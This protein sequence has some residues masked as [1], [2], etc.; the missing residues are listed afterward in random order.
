M[1]LFKTIVIIFISFMMFGCANT[2]PKFTSLDRIVHNDKATVYFYRIRGFV[3]G[4]GSGG[5]VP[6]IVNNKLIGKLENN[7]Y[8]KV[9]FTEGQYKIHSQNSNIIDRILNIN[10]KAGKTYFIKNE[11]IMGMWV[12]SVIY[13]EVDQH[14]AFEEMK[15]T[16]IQLYD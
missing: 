7:A 9:L 13:T 4:V 6:I 8:T 15:N 12:C 3:G 5:L 10:F 16:G 2:G 14:I 11:I 1:K